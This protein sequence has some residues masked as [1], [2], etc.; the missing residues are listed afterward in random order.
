[1]KIVVNSQLGYEVLD[2]TGHHGLRSGG[3][4]GTRPAH[5]ESKKLF[6]YQ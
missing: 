5:G 1:M 2:L 6:K 4:V 3:S